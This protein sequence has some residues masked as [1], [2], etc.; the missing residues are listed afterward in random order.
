M[1]R[2]S[3]AAVRS[4]ALFN[5]RVVLCSLVTAEE[6]F[7]LCG[8]QHITLSSAALALIQKTPLDAKF[9][10]I[11]DR[12]LACLHGDRKVDNNDAFFS[13]ASLEQ[14]LA[15]PAVDALQ[16]DALLHFGRAEEELREM[17]KKACQA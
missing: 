12:S 13:E 1:R 2:K 14:V 5:A 4:D 10:G 7:A 8:I 15:D 3:T 11:R 6:V 9:E 17:A 16:R